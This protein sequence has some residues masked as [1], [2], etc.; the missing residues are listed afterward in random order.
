MKLEFLYRC[1]QCAPWTQRLTFLSVQLL[2]KLNWIRA[3]SYWKPW[4]QRLNY[5]L[6]AFKAV[7]AAAAAAMSHQLRMVLN[8]QTMSRCQGVRYY[9][10][11]CVRSF[12]MKQ[13]GREIVPSKYV[14]VVLVLCSW[15]KFRTSSSH[16]KW[17]CVS[18]SLN[19]Y[20]KFSI[21][22]DGAAAVL[23]SYVHINIHGFCN[24]YIFRICYMPVFKSMWTVWIS[25]FHLLRTNTPFIGCAII[26]L[27]SR[28][29]FILCVC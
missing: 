29:S 28:F 18:L 8:S 4:E 1:T 19:V 2:G 11:M 27:E 25:L 22:F 6:N 21:Q 23:F 12:E 26:V 7:A 24:N 9:V 15:K 13:L 3:A 16:L 10:Y 5:I 14:C 20:G 17:M